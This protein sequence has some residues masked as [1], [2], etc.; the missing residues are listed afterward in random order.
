MDSLPFQFPELLG[1]IVDAGGVVRA[2]AD[3]LT[4]EFE[5]KDNLLGVMRSDV[6]RVAIP[7]DQIDEVRLRSNIFRTELEI[8]A[9]SIG[10]VTEVPGHKQG[11]VRL[12]IPRE[13]RR[14]ARAMAYEASGKV[15]QIKLDR[16][17][18]GF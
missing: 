8:R 4:L 11:R 2:D 7:F 16:L 15:S 13:Y 3:A 1:G 18:R 12:K 14:E 6:Q 5:I 9:N 10:V 17:E